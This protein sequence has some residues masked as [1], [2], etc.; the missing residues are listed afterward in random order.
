MPNGHGHRHTRRTPH[1]TLEPP[2]RPLRTRL[3]QGT[4]VVDGALH[5]GSDGALAPTGAPTA[6]PVSL[7]EARPNMA[8]HPVVDDST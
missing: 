1:T 5:G 4:V 3:Y 6:H 7:R 2:H 8:E